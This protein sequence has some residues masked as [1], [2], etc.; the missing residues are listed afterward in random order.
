M[1]KTADEFTPQRHNYVKTESRASKSK[2]TDFQ[3]AV[4]EFDDQLFL[5]SVVNVFR[6]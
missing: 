6:E 4:F 2:T 5:E 1:A 3:L